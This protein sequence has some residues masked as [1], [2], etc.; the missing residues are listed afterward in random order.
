MFLS[1]IHEIAL[2]KFVIETTAIPLKND[3]ETEEA[4]QAFL[5]LR[6]SANGQ[7][8]DSDSDADTEY[9]TEVTDDANSAF[10]SLTQ[11]KLFAMFGFL[12]QG[13]HH[14]TNVDLN[15]VMIP[16]PLHK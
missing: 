7:V 13:I 8:S 12:I 1:H 14:V 9:E 6:E 16:R 5:S 10:I 15:Y 3:F 11:L 4:E 2:P